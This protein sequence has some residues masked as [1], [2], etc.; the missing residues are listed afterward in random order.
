MRNHLPVPVVDPAEYE[1]E[2]DGVGVRGLTLSLDQLKKDFPAV[3]VT[4]A[5]MCA[6]QLATVSLDSACGVCRS[7]WVC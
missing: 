4:A 2:V 6:G 1:L 5:I 3:T 7:E